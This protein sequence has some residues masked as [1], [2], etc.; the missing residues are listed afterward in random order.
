MRKRLHPA[1]RAAFARFA[2]TARAL[3]RTP[4][5]YHAEAQAQ[6][7]DLHGGAQ[8]L[9]AHERRGVELAARHVDAGET[10]LVAGCG[11]G[12]EIG[13]LRDL[14]VRE[15]RGLEIS[16]V[17]ARRCAERFGIDVAVGDMAAP[18]FAPRSFDVVIT[19]R[20]LHHMLHPYQAL[21][22]LA[23]LARRTVIVADEPVVSIIKRARD[24]LRGNR[25]VADDASWEFQFAPAMLARHMGYAGFEPVATARYW[26]TTRPG[27]DRFANALSRRLGNRLTMVFRR[28]PG[29]S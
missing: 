23:A 28:L 9:A 16:P 22:A 11:A 5:Q 1:D 25:L 2:A 15:L 29:T 14:G 10:C 7:R 21:E 20:S 19:H 12:A 6:A 4:S 8:D 27:N 3:G 26:E 13:A 24:L 18:P 17:L